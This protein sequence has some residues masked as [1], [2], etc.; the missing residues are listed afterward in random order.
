MCFIGFAPLSQIIPDCGY[1]VHHGGIGTTFATLIA[2]KPAIVMPQAYDQFFNATLIDRWG[3]G[4][5]QMRVGLDT[6]LTELRSRTILE[7]RAQSLAKELRTPQQAAKVVLD[8][9]TK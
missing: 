9:I 2:G 1:V 6:A 7:D 5:D 3:A 8:R 4:I